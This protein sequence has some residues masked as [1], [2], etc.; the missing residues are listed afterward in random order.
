MKFIYTRF[1]NVK[2]REH[3]AS[4]SDLFYIDWKRIIHFPTIYIYCIVFCQNLKTTFKLSKKRGKKRRF[5]SFLI[6][7]SMKS[8]LIS[9]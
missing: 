8:A 1:R 5:L 6:M 4:L 9:L 3:Y 2:K 7:F